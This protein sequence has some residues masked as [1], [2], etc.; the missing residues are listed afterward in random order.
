MIEYLGFPYN[1][2]MSIIFKRVC[3]E[4]FDATYTI[5]FLYECPGY[6]SPIYIL[7]TTRFVTGSHT[8][9]EFACFIYSATETGMTLHMDSR[10]F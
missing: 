8:G 4:Y 1:Y 2:L 9:S 5:N 6:A 3:G 7:L 10:W